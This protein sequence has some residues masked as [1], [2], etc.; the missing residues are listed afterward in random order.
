MAGNR[1]I[2]RVSQVAFMPERRLRH[3]KNQQD[4]RPQSMQPFSVVA[5][6]RQVVELKFRGSFVIRVIPIKRPAVSG[7]ASCLSCAGPRDIGPRHARATRRVPVRAGPGRERA[8]A[9]GASLAAG[10][11]AQG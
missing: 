4:R 6:A 7:R 3:R 2:R 10:L 5:S 8:R 11:P 1:L 9:R